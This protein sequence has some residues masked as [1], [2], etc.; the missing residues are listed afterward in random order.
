MKR[1]PNTP[2]R[3]RPRR[4]QASVSESALLLH[5]KAAKPLL[6]SHVSRGA[7]VEAPHG[8]EFS[9][10][11]RVYHFVLYTLA[12]RAKVRGKGEGKTLSAGQVLVVPS[13]VP[14]VCTASNGIWRF[15][16]FE[17]R[18]T[19]K[20]SHL[21]GQGLS[22]RPT[23]VER[24]IHAAL[25][26]YLEETAR[27]TEDS[28]RA[29]SLY[30]ELLALYLARDLKPSGSDVSTSM[31]GF[32]AAL[33][34]KVSRDLGRD[35]RVHE[36]AAEVGVAPSHFYRLVRK[37]NG[38]TPL[39]MVLRVRMERAQE[40]LLTEDHPLRVVSDLVGY[41]DPFAFSAAFKRIV[42]VNPSEFCKKRHAEQTP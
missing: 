30:A 19:E 41:D 29:A 18:D 6:E 39:N 38:D 26:A 28:R 21:A 32:L 10:P 4:G 23:L 36:L 9:R 8:A 22:V 5:S 3:N 35:W 34:D 25:D 11:S 27:H 12:G 42:G 7:C 2:A 31:E 17:L 15:V 37:F 14:F 33:W 20:W 16:W 1:Q 24:R 13:H 40:L